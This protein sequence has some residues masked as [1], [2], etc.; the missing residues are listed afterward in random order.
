MG[1]DTTDNQ[2]LYPD[3]DNFIVV[4]DDVYHSFHRALNN[5]EQAMKIL[6]DVRA[7]ISQTENP[8]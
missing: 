1:A 5:V 4:P 7:K 6:K 2:S 3:E 8:V